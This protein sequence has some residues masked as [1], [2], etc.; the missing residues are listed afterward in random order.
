MDNA[1][2]NEPTNIEIAV[3]GAPY[4]IS[5]AASVIELVKQLDFAPERLAVELNLNIL[6]R[7]QW[8]ETK[9]QAGDKLEIVHFVG[10]G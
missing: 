7:T 8:A 1:R 2:V 10:G 9:L 4:Q 3:N 6:P 5:A